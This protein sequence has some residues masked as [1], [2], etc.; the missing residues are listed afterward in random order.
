VRCKWDKRG[1][2]STLVKGILLPLVGF[3]VIIGVISITY[4]TAQASPAA[5]LSSCAASLKMGSTA[6]DLTGPLK[7]LFKSPDICSTIEPPPIPQEGTNREDIEK[8]VMELI[9][10]SWKV[11]LEGET[12]IFDKGLFNKKNCFIVFLFEIEE[13][14][15]FQQGDIITRSEFRKHLEEYPYKSFTEE[16]ET[17]EYTYDEYVQDKGKPGRIEVFPPP[18]DCKKT[19]PCYKEYEKR[20]DIGFKPKGVYAIA[21]VSPTGVF[22]W[23]KEPQSMIN[24]VIVDEDSRIR[25]NC[26]EAT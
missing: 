23:F 26:H 5:K 13:T 1:D 19:D 12:G 14:R 20:E 11:T 7:Y 10:K 8:E 4:T 25:G 18:N 22:K 3:V 6:E 9:A 21:V 17:T 2:W 24:Y 16:G 15:F